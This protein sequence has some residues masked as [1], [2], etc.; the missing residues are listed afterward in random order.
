MYLEIMD[1]N[2]ISTCSYCCKYNHFFE[3]NFSSSFYSI[4]IVYQSLVLTILVLHLIMYCFALEKCLPF[5]FKE[6]KSPLN[7]V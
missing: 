3:S 6:D 5:I 4:F 1:K 2:K 7:S